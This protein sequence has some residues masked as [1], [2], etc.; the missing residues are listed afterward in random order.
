MGILER[1]R[2]VIRADLNDLLKKASNPRAIL[3]A[4]LDDLEMILDEAVSIR[5]TEETERDMYAARLRDIRA[6]METMEK[7]AKVCLKNNDE[8]LARTAL[9]RKLDLQEDAA[10]LKKEL[11][12]R[13]DSLTILEE[14]VHGLK[15][16]IT[17]VNRRLREMRFRH[18]I[19]QA[20]S[21][22][23]QT[24]NRAGH[25]QDEPMLSQ[26]RDDL[27][28][29]EGRLEAEESLRKDTLDDRVLRMEVAERRR[30]R[31][32]VVDDELASLRRKLTQG[33]QKQKKA[34]NKKR[35]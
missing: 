4:Y 31:R 2:H 27:S 5:N 20:R 26:A 9:E 8:E 14:S 24:M 11:D 30:Q 3:D 28:E 18:Q 19:L 6:V 21:E 23:Q 17:E 33:H 29:L 35:G 13:T 12:Q 1:T 10:D 34:G 32:R 15:A 7:K 16:R 25:D 22:L